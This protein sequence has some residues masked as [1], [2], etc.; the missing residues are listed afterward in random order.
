[1]ELGAVKFPW[2]DPD[3]MAADANSLRSQAKAVSA[4]LDEGDVLAYHEAA[5]ALGASPDEVDPVEPDRLRTFTLRFVEPVQQPNPEPRSFAQIILDNSLLITMVVGALV[6][7]VVGYQTQSST[8]HR[9]TAGTAR[10]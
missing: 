5:L 1:M 10:T 9:S 2:A 3:K 7:A 4:A 8:T 6:V